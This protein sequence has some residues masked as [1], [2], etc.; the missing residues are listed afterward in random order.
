M[1]NN[2]LSV[3]FSTRSISNGYV[4]HIEKTCG[5][6]NVLEV[7]P[8]ENNGEHSL[9]EIYN[10]GLKEAKGD[11]IVFCHDDLIFETLEWGKK[12]LQHF[13]NNPEY[14]II[15]IAGSNHLVDGKWWS[16]RESMHGIVNHTDGFRK[17]TSMFSRP[18]DGIVKEMVVLDGLFFA[19]DKT[20]I[21]HEFDTDFSGF[22]FYDLSFCLPNYLDGVKIGLTTD[23][24]LTH[25]SVGQ[26]NQKWE[27][28]KKLFE[29]KY[30]NKLPVKI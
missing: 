28:N 10:M 14:G 9:T 21:K 17:W 25:L 11:I 29:D 13:N 12:L 27:D 7:L 30:S 2:K 24:I 22:H 19:I 1:S 6:D 16:L 3:V 8:Y 5:Y 15:G 4:K 26:T 18:Q 20:K 23:I